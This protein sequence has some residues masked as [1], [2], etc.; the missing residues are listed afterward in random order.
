M[1]RW[2][3]LAAQ[4]LNSELP[5]H[6]KPEKRHKGATKTVRYQEA[7]KKYRDSSKKKEELDLE[8]LEL[9]A[10]QERADIG[11]M[12][13][14]EGEDTP[15][16]DK[17]TELTDRE[18]K[19]GVTHL[20]HCWYP[21]GHSVGNLKF[22]LPSLVADSF[23]GE[24]GTLFRYDQDRPGYYGCEDILQGHPEGLS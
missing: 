4:Y 2:V 6:Y 15:S 24:D 22:I 19:T 16:E 18:E 11:G 20:V 12:F 8:A 21:T 7:A 1:M 5:P 10:A 13:L 3:H 9:V 23:P 17:D 14:D